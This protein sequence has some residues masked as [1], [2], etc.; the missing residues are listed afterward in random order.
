VVTAK[1][2]QSLIVDIAHYSRTLS[3]C[4]HRKSQQN[5]QRREEIFVGFPTV[6]RL[7][8]HHCRARRAEMRERVGWWGATEQKTGWWWLT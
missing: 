4:V 8:G 1:P 6:R 5:R 7:A 3:P 2:Q